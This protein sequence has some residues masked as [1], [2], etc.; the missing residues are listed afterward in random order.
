MESITNEIKEYF[1]LNKRNTNIMNMGDTILD[2]ATEDGIYENWC[3]INNKSARSDFIKGKNI[4]NTRDA[5]DGRHPCVHCNTGVTN[6]K[7][8]WQPSWILKSCPV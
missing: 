3:L 6:N 4:S 1:S 8:N 2:A 5:T 7:N